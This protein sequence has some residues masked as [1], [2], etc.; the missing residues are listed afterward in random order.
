M[1][2][3]NQHTVRARARV[4]Q[5]PAPQRLQRGYGCVIVALV[6]KRTGV[7]GRPLEINLKTLCEV[8][9]LGGSRLRERERRPEEDHAQPRV[10]PTVCRLARTQRRLEYVRDPVH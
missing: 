10:T 8:T 5:D 4:A 6:E 3:A 9:R 2:A 1:L 7:C